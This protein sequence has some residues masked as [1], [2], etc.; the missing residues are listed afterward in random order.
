MYIPGVLNLEGQRGKPTIVRSRGV[1][2]VKPLQGPLCASA[3]CVVGWAAIEGRGHL[4]TVFVFPPAAAI[5]G[6]VVYGPPLRYRLF[7]KTR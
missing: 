2:G 3:G 7:R 4:S 1:G 6:P 5:V